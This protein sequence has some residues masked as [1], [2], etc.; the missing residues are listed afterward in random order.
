L[1]FHLY[2]NQQHRRRSPAA[3]CLGED[4]HARRTRAS[5]WLSRGGCAC[6]AAGMERSTPPR[7][8]GWRRD[9][10]HIDPLPGQGGEGRTQAGPF[11]SENR[12]SGTEG[13]AMLTVRN[14][15]PLNAKRR[16]N[17]G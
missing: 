6:T 14:A 16:G 7:A 4:D 17:V 10:R 11:F 12:A 9:A 1:C 13:A 2:I 5:A 15:F 8:R 3:R